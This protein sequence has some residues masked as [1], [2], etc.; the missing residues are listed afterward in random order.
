MDGGRS[1]LKSVRNGSD[2]N[3]STRSEGV[4]RPSGTAGWA[5]SGLSGKA[6]SGRLD[7]ARGVLKRAAR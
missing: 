6:T 3:G 7:G 1:R 2:T 5:G 4:G